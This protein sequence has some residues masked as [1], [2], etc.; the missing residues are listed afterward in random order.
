MLANVLPLHTPLTSE[1]RS[2]CHFFLSSESSRV[3]CQIKG[4]KAENSMQANSPPFYTFT[5]PR[6][7]QK[8]KTSDT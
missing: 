2:K 6:C 1:V 5:A 3:S 7:D 4:N 8:V